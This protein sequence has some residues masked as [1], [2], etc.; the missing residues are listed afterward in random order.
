MQSMAD[1]PYQV[2]QINLYNNKI[3]CVQ[4]YHFQTS[5]YSQF[6]PPLSAAVLKLTSE[7]SRSLKDTIY[8][9]YPLEY[10]QEV[11]RNYST[12][13]YVNGTDS[14]DNLTMT[15]RNAIENYISSCKNI[16][17]HTIIDRMYNINPMLIQQQ[18]YY[19]T[20]NGDSLIP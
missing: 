2:S 12:F 17:D 13:K 15:Y 1:I 14:N 18:A 7:F 5:N 20:A 19:I 4:D 8:V 6:Y 3:W 9:D 11:S 16:L 10:N